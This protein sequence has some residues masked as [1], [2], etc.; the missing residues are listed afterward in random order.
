MVGAIAVLALLTVS[1]GIG[2]QANASGAGMSGSD[3][4]LDMGA[5]AYGHQG[6]QAAR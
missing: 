4:L 6:G 5:I 1:I 3:F 2:I